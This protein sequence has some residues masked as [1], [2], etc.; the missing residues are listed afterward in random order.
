MTTK[1]MRNRKLEVHFAVRDY[2]RKVSRGKVLGTCMALMIGWS[3]SK[4]R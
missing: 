4:E 1:L 3:N 2:M